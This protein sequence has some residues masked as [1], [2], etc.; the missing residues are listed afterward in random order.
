MSR[1]TGVGRLVGAKAILR[2]LRDRHNIDIKRT[3]LWKMTQDRSEARFPADLTSYL[4][5]LRIVAY[6]RTIDAWVRVH[7]DTHQP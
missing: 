4:G 2:Y 5:R 3:K 7:V 1:R 6:E